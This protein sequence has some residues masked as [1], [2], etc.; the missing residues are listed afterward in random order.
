MKHRADVRAC[1]EASQACLTACEHWLSAGATDTPV[2]ARLS[3]VAIALDCVQYARMLVQFLERES[4]HVSLVCEDGADIF[5]AAAELFEHDADRDSQQCAE[6]CRA[7]SQ[8]C[9]RLVQSP[10]NEASMVA[11]GLPRSGVGAIHHEA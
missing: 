2:P 11:A 10:I 8:S 7:A 4:R 6:T 3:T 9:L 5:S 1:I